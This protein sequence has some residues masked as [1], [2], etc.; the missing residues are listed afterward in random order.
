[1]NFRRIVII[2]FGILITVLLYQLLLKSNH[3]TYTVF[4]RT[5]LHNLNTVGSV[6]PL[7]DATARTITKHII[8]YAQQLK[9]SP[10]RVLELGAGTGTLSTQ[11]IQGLENTTLPYHID[12]IELLPEYADLLQKKFKHNP[13]VSVFN[14]DARAFEPPYKYQ[15][16]ISTLPFNA[17]GFDYQTVEEIFKKIVDISEPGALLL[18]VEYAAIPTFLRLFSMGQTRVN[19]T[20]KQDFLTHFKNEHETHQELIFWNIPPTWLYRQIL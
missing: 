12:L 3:Q 20:K 1:M 10:M 18:W 4:F 16:I 17:F 9:Q 6:V 11:I 19:F 7:S 5:A 13:N 14:S 15:I 8:T 2:G